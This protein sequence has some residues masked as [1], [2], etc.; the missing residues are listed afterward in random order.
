MQSRTSISHAVEPKY[1]L[2]VCGNSQADN[3][4]GDLFH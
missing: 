1:S 4:C 2:L 3:C